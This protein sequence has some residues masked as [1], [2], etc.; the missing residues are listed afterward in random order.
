MKTVIALGFF[1]GVHLG[2]QALMARAVER[3]REHG[4]EPAVF[5]F[6]RSPR[7]FVT[8]KPVPLLTSPEERRRLVEESF[9]IRRV[10]VA[11]FDRAMMTMPWMD[12]L[13]V[14]AGRYNAG[15]LVA[16]HDFRFGHRNEGDAALLARGAAELGMGWDIIPAV[17]VDGV[18]V[19]STRIRSLLEE[20]RAEEAGRLLGR[21]FSIAGTIAHG[22]GLGSRIGRPTLNLLPGGDQLIPARGVYVAAAELAGRRFPAVTNVGVRPTVD[23]DGGVTVE[24]HLLEAEGDFYGESCR[25]SLLKRLRPEEEFPGLRELQAQIAADAEAAREYFRKFPEIIGGF[26]P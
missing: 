9:P 15:W 5:T 19:S 18:T 23:R 8:G 2:H 21:P 17:A 10:I 12:F 6:D 1:D 14:L 11:K 3:G 22:K 26:R 24:S 25:V 4:L 13:R 20:G 7:E 16:G